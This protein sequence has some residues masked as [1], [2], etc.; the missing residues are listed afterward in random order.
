MHPSIGNDVEFILT[1]GRTPISAIGLVGGSK[2]CPSPCPHGALQEDNVLAE[3]NIYPA[4]DSDRWEKNIVAVVSELRA[5]IGPEINI[6][7]KASA[8]FP[9]AEL[10]SPKAQEFGCDPDINAWTQR[11]N[12]FIR[13][14]GKM[15]R[16]RSAGGHVHIGI[17]SLSAEDGFIIIQCLDTFVG[18][19]GVLL[20]G[21]KRRKLLYGKAGSMRFK[22][23][24]VEWRTPSNFWAH[25]PYS[26]KWMFDSA[27]FVAKN[28]KTLHKYVLLQNIPQVI[29]N[30]DKIKARAIL[31][32]LRKDV[33]FPSY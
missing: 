28:Y 16:L 29:N 21:D 12:M 14:G 26:R 10:C 22:P 15:E 33:D 31:D 4:Q 1:R 30:D 3:I 32:K 9:V 11:E 2:D 8:L 7:T 23:Y 13:P 19:Q 6:S 5:R 24:G 18:L 25:D 20:D 27:M 17:P